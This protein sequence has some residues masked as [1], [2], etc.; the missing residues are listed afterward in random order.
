MNEYIKIAIDGP[1]ASGKSS[2]ARLIAKKLD[3]LYLDTGSMYRCLTLMLLR[4]GY[5][6]KKI[7]EDKNIEQTLK[8]YFDKFDYSYS[9][10][11]IY[12]GDEDIT[13]LLNSN[14]INKNVSKISQIPYVRKSMIE[15][16]QRIAKDNSI[17]MDGRDIG[18]AVLPDAD[19]KFHI[20]ADVSIRAKRRYEQLVS[21][22]SNESVEKIE[23]DLE[24]R[25]YLDTKLDTSP[26]KNLASDVVKIDNSSMSLEE[27]ANHIIEIIN[28]GII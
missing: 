15:I 9:K 23:K 4:D 13:S 19:Y 5:I 18:T 16:Q 10:G 11:R 1:S 24:Y 12:L 14:E 20:N 7:Y 27:T 22:S 17:V 28:A 25:D 2:L 8:K 26:M 6:N 21:G 3:I